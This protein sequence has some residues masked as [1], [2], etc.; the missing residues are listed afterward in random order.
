VVIGGQSGKISET[1]DVRE[2]EFLANRVVRYL[3]RHALMRKWSKEKWRFTDEHHLQRD[4]VRDLK[5]R[6]K[7]NFACAEHLRR[8]AGGKKKRLG[9]VI[10]GAVLSKCSFS[11]KKKT[12]VVRIPER[13]R[14]G[15]SHLKH[16]TK[17]ERL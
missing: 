6:Q 8:F 3:E 12:A 5:R 4:V 2:A 11:P 13:W 1:R 17:C 7:T 10:A 9:S 14:E 15:A 16:A